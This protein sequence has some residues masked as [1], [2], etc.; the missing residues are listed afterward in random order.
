M[1]LV[2]VKGYTKSDGTKVHS[3][4]KDVH[5]RVHRK[6]KGHRLT[7][8]AMGNLVYVRKRRTAMHRR[9]MY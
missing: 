1:P 3:Y 6:K 5:G 4:Y 8:D 9:R 2:K 7:M